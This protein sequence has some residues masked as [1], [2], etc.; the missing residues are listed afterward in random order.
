MNVSGSE[1]LQNLSKDTLRRNPHL[2]EELGKIE[3]KKAKYNNE[4][5]IVDGFL[6]DSTR[7]A[8]YYSQLKI[9]K[10]VGEIKDFT[11]QVRFLL[12]E[13]YVK[14]G[15]KIKPEYLVVDFLVTFPDGRQEVHDPKGFKTALYKSK[16]KRFE[17]KYPHLKFVEI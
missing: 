12:E 5:I 6:F 8:N 15:K 3:P 7:E 1:L 14:D 16:K 9:L 17:K 13:G 10:R 2:V 11:R 4:K